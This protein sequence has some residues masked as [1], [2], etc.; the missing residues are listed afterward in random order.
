MK[1]LTI[2][3]IALVLVSGCSGDPARISPYRWRSVSPEIDTLT[4]ELESGFNDYAPHDL[5]K[6]EVEEM[7]R[8]AGESAEEGMTLRSRYWQAR[9][10]QREGLAD[11]AREEVERILAEA[12]SARYPYEFFR[13]RILARQLRG[14]RD[15]RSYFYIDQEARFFDSIGDLPMTAVSYIN[16]AISLY[17]LGEL[18]RS[19]GYLEKADDINRSLGMEGLVAKNAINI[20][21]IYIRKGEKEKGVALLRGLLDDGSLTADSTTHNLVL[22]N[23]YVYTNE[24]AYLAGAYADVAGNDNM[25]D[26]QGIYQA[27]L[28]LHYAGIE[29][30]GDSADIY[31]RL[32]LGN[33][34]YVDDY[35]HKG[36]IMQAYAAT[37][38]REG[39]TDSALVYLKRYIEC[40][41]SDYVAMQQ[42]EVLRMANMREVSLAMSQEHK[43]TQRMRGNFF[44]ILLVIITLASVVSF[45]L[46]RRQKRHEIA[47]RD[48]Q[49]EMEK[50]RRNLLA[51]MLTIEEKNNL[52]GSLKSEIEK[53]RKE[54]SIG[55]PEA[56]RLQ[57]VIFMQLAGG[58][59][60]DTFQQQF[61]QVYPGFVSRFHKAYPGLADSYVKLATYIYM[62]LDNNAIARLLVIRPESVKQARWRL[63]RMMGLEKGASLDDAIRALGD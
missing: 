52:F 39:K 36:Y 38:E 5:L 27:L 32:A 8:L 58:D 26:L 3:L 44:V 10:L 60:L 21:G 17:P 23:L 13:L 61:V 45:I 4:L 29:G 28:S 15:A 1:C 37:M 42:A 33:V 48:S 49:L 43:R 14:R 51:L 31:S 57:N 54:G 41:D 63:R 20:A 50:S 9:L 16:L 2:F 30:K 35:G 25:R 22:R 12:D 6:S 59:E 11:S 62:G 24:V 46:Y 7:A 53:M 34:D 47:V 18:D 19:L 56:T 40:S 55:G